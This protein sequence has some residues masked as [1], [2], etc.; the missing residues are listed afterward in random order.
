MEEDVL[1]LLKIVQSWQ[2]EVYVH[3]SQER[4]IQAV[5]GDRVDGLQAASVLKKTKKE[6]NLQHW[7]EKA[8]HGQYL[9]QTKEVRSE[10]LCVW[11]QIRDLKRQT[12]SLIVAAQNQSIR[13][14]L[15]KV[16]TDKSQKDTLCRL[17][18]KADESIDHVDIGFSRLAQKKYKRRHKNLGKIVHWKLARK[19]NFE[20]G[21]KWCIE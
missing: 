15:V 14:N 12:E 4:L 8:L 10:Q 3:R 16:K 20:A 5:R 18:K 6:K 9:R 7:E 2:L 13:T 11:L 17:R 19:C 21:D 1:Q